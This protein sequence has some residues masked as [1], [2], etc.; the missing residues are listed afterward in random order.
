MIEEKKIWDRGLRHSYFSTSSTTSS[1][2]STSFYSS[3]SRPS[4]NGVLSLT[5]P[6]KS[7]IKGDNHDDR[8][9]EKEK[10]RERENEKKKKQLQNQN[11]LLRRPKAI[12]FSQNQELHVRTV[13]ITL[14]FFSFFLYFSC[15]ILSSGE[16]NN[17]D[18]QIF[19]FKKKSLHSL[20]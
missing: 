5:S 16:M 10:E 17:L 20:N 14:S 2:Y 9:K 1:S 11:Y 8:E 12:V 3:P 15:T 18:L 4:S 6:S 13:F 7:S 19:L